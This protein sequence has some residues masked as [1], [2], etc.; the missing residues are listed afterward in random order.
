LEK[1]SVINKGFREKDS[2]QKMTTSL[3]QQFCDEKIKTLKKKTTW[4]SPN[5]GT[6]TYLPTKIFK[7][8]REH[9]VTFGFVK[10]WSKA[11]VSK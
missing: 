9:F 1:R 10:C 2:K 8:R 7:Q 6:Q 4:I 5:F 3:L 11:I